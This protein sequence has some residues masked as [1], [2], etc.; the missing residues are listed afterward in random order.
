MHLGH[1]TL[2][3]GFHPRLRLLAQVH[4]VVHQY[5]GLLVGLDL[6]EHGLH[7]FYAR[8]P[9]GVCP[10]HH[11]QQQA[12]VPGFFQRGA[13]CGHQLM[14]QVAYEAHRVGQH[15]MFARRQRQAP[16]RWVQGRE[17]LGGGVAVVSGQRVEQGRFAGIG[18]TH[19]RNRGN[20]I[21]G[22]GL[23]RLRS[24][25]AHHFQ[26]LLQRG[27]TVAQQAPVGFQLGFARPAQADTAFLSLQ[28]RPTAH[29]AG[30]QM[31]QLGQFHL[32]LALVGACA[33][34]EDI[35]DQAGAIQHP[36]FQPLFQI[37][38]L[39]GRQAVIEDHQFGAFGGHQRSHFVGLAAA[40]KQTGVGPLALAA[41]E[42]N[43]FG[44]GGY[45]QLPEFLTVS[46]VIAAREFK[47]HQYR[48]LAGWWPLKHWHSTRQIFYRAST[49]DQASP[50]APLSSI[51][52]SRRMA[53][54]G[55]TVEIACL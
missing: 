13:E 55:T 39:T 29:Q 2:R 3:I 37:A 45:R 25:P 52:V 6:L 34:G 33:L 9:L 49:N 10:V 26:A 32:Q 44:A 14:R 46:F 19:Q 4:L 50:S 23:A 11:M 21:A 24:P 54:E 43:D 1:R 31:I 22:S 18:V 8:A 12:G 28:V 47:I 7:L 16:Q 48:T 27:D 41:Y 38:F 30:R 42:V 20:F 51:S 36:A 40:G 17:Q 53:R 15:D 5:A 35:Q